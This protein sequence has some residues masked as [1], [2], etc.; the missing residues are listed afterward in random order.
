MEGTSQT[1]TQGSHTTLFFV[2]T[3]NRL[4]AHLGVIDQMQDF[5]AA[6]G[7]QV[8]RDGRELT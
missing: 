4:S 6:G 1:M 5:R 7:I 3:D 8:P 2:N